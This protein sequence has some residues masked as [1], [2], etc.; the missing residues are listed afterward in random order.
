MIIEYG[1]PLPDSEVLVGIYVDDLLVMHI[2]DKN[3]VCKYK[4]PDKDIITKTHQAYEWA[5]LPRSKDKDF[6]F[7]TGA[8]GAQGLTSFT[9]W[10]TGVDSET[11]VVGTAI[12]KRISIAFC[13][14]W[15]LE[16]REVQKLVLIRVVALCVHPF[17]HLRMCMSAF[18]RMYKYLA[19]FERDSDMVPL[20]PDIKDELVVRHHR[21]KDTDQHAHH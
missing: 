21:H 8:A 4:G 7:G 3:Q 14:F 5:G 18:H 16:F 13:I 9:A 6:G 17:M 11:G 20:V 1:S 15:L 10:G 12:T 19:S 2:F